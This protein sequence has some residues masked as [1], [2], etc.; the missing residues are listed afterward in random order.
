M[1]E[2]LSKEF[3]KVPGIQVYIDRADETEIPA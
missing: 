3:L 2:I 1:A